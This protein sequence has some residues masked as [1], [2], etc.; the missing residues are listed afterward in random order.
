V[1]N[2]RPTELARRP[3]DVVKRVA[4]GLS[5][6]GGDTIRETPASAAEKVVCL[7]ASVEQWAARLDRQVEGVVPGGARLGIYLLA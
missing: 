3:T 2:A 1:L 4:T 6:R 7:S 5:D